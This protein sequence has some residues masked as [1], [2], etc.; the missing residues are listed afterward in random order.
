VAA[1]AQSPTPRLRLER[2]AAWVA[3]AREHVPGLV[4]EPLLRVTSFSSIELERVLLDLP[5]VFT[6]MRNPRESPGPRF[7]P[8]T[9]GVPVSTGAYSDDERV[10]L[11]DIAT[12]A[13]RRGDANLVLK[14]G[15]LLHADIM[16]M[17]REGRTAPPG[18]ASSGSQLVTVLAGDGRQVGMEDE[19]DH[20]S[21]GRRLLDRV[22]PDPARNRRDPAGDMD[23][24]RWY[25]GVG[26]FMAYRDVLDVAHFKR[27]VEIFP[28]DG[29]ILLLAGSIHERL[30]RPSVQRVVQSARLPG[31]LVMDIGSA[32]EELSRAESLLRRSVR[33]A[34][35][36]VEAHVRLG[37]V[38]GLRGDHE[39]ALAVLRAVVPG[40]SDPLLRFYGELFLGAEAEMLGEGK[41]ARS[42]Y[43]RAAT[44][45][46]R[47]Q[48][49]RI[50]LSRLLHGDGAKA[51]ALSQ[52]RSALDG[53]RQDIDDPWWAYS[54]AAGRH[55][56]RSLEELRAPFLPPGADPSARPER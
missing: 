34:P 35:T 44:L 12:E 16:M 1:Q 18:S 24:R 2:L 52:V 9:R 22:G 43:E 56:A 8:R 55:V 50:A 21:I 13:R 26:A 3:A 48:S 37:R 40:I 7:E 30:A 36:L 33:A 51:D 23:V 42:S 32:R 45:Y 54:S 29:E 14:R 4:D 19:V 11:R 38:L 47:A 20:R 5:N 46:P 10:A 25:R 17:P 39:E 53:P 27:A 31:D 15:A 28:A 6:L 49:P 41:L